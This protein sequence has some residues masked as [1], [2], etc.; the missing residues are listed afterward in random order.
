MMCED[1]KHPIECTIVW[2]GETYDGVPKEWPFHERCADQPWPLY[3]VRREH[4]PPPT[5]ASA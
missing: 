4:Q 3:E 2:L 5:E 1:C